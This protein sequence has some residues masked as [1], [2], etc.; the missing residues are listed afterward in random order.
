MTRPLPL[1]R[2]LMAAATLLAGGLAVASTIAPADA[3]TVVAVRPVRTIPV[4]TQSPLPA[5]ANDGTLYL[6]SSG[7]IQQLAP[8]SDGSNQHVLKTFTGF[9]PSSNLAIG[10]NGIAFA[11]GA[12][13][14]VFDPSQ[15]AGAI[16]PIH[17]I[18]GANTTLD[19]PGAVA[20]GADGSLWTLDA[21]PSGP[22]DLLRFAPG[23]DGNA[24]PT[25]VI[26]GTHT[27]MVGAFS[28][29][30][31]IAALPA[32][33]IAFAANS[34]QPSISVWTGAQHGNVAPARVIR[35]PAPT[36]HWLAE[37]LASDPQ[38][39][40]YIGAGDANGNAFGALYVFAPTAN[41][42]AT[43]LLTLGGPA[44]RFEIP[45]APSVSSNGTLALLDATIIALGSSTQQ[46]AQIEVFRPL[47]ARPGAVR[48]L[49]VTPSRTSQTISWLA[50]A[51]PGGTPPSYRVVVRKGTRT[52]LS[53]AVAG[54]RLVVA[55]SALPKGSLKVTVTAVNVGGAGPGASRT[56][57][58]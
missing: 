13:L 34:V 41:G 6:P 50:P 1:R 15:L 48:S 49:K 4:G 51:N 52:V 21:N 36:P 2:A 18:T 55:R 8:D 23:A 3:A 17:T 32:G 35:V 42:D 28:A 53:K 27:N 5:V 12:S 25:K 40:L 44:Q 10:P 24:T 43:P 30:G 19:G 37:G 29:G 11:S 58:D 33:G 9:T 31:F 14:V 16:T 26:G 7:Q 38:G 57:T 47:F 45:L 46:A 56:F 22:P 20:W 54:T 39:R